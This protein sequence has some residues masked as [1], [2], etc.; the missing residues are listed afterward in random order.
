MYVSVH[1]MPLA[2]GTLTPP[3]GR[4]LHV[5]D[6]HSVS[7]SMQHHAP[8]V[9]QA[10]LLGAPHPPGPSSSPIIRPALVRVEE[11]TRARDRLHLGLHSRTPL[12]GVRGAGIIRR[13]TPRA[14]FRLCFSICIG[15][16]VRAKFG[17]R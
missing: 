2:V 4:H 1:G 12:C 5:V 16:I 8:L 6:H 15:R 9:V 10:R 3:H 14:Y 17:R 11:R 7:G 13:C